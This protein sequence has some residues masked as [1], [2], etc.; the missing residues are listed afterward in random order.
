MGNRPRAGA[1]AT[2]TP[3][4]PEGLVLF[5]AH[6]A[7]T[8]GRRPHNK[9]VMWE[10]LYPNTP[11]QPTTAPSSEKSR[12]AGRVVKLDRPPFAASSFCFQVDQS[13]IHPRERVFR[14]V[15]AKSAQH[16]SPWGYCSA[17][18]LK[19]TSFYLHHDNSAA[20]APRCA[21][22]PKPVS[23]T[24]RLRQCPVSSVGQCDSSGQSMNLFQ[25]DLISCYRLE[26]DDRRD[27]HIALVCHCNCAA[28]NAGL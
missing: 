26:I 3:T 17:I 28:L 22:A 20:V 9:L 24:M 7:P 25:N 12:P 19:R 1:P 27:V 21:L 15:D 23:F 8:R 14:A 4:K 16:V 13:R 5:G 18:T 11:Q 10:Q 2:K 6:D